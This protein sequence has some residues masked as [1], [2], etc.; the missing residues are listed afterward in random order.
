MPLP[1]GGIGVQNGFHPQS[2]TSQTH[3]PDL[4]ATGSFTVQRTHISAYRGGGGGRYVENISTPLGKFLF[5]IIH[6][7]NII[8][9]LI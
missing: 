7:L 4:R 8:K 9:C 6:M 5:Y 1:A 3:D 2:V